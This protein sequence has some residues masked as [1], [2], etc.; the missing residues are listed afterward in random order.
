LPGTLA[1]AV[2]ADAGVLRRFLEPWVITA[3]KDPKAACKDPRVAAA[4]PAGKED[5]LRGLM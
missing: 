2:G 4:R 1:P 3:G 5:Q